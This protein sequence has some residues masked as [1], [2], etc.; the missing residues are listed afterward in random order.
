MTYPHDTLP[1]QTPGSISTPVLSPACMPPWRMA[2]SGSCSW[3]ITTRMSEQVLQKYTHANAQTGSDFQIE[4]FDFHVMCLGGYI[5]SVRSFEDKMRKEWESAPKFI[6]YICKR[7]AV[8]IKI[9]I[10]CS[11]MLHEVKGNGPFIILLNNL[12]TLSLLGL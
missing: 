8:T 12:S 10:L 3:K 7:N 11:D 1:Q 5:Y 4:F 6:F 9:F 2:W